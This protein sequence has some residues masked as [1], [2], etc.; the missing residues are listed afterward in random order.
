MAWRTGWFVSA[1]RRC[2][3]VLQVRLAFASLTM[4][5]YIT[6]FPKSKPY[7]LHLKCVSSIHPVTPKQHR[8]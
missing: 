2:L 1:F 7:I 4:D 6:V 3:L 8:I 5:T